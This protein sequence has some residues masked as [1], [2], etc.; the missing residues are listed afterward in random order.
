MAARVVELAAAAEGHLLA[1]GPPRSQVPALVLERGNELDLPEL[2][3]QYL[4]AHEAELGGKV[5]L[6]G[7]HQQLSGP[8]GAGDDVAG[9]VDAADHR[10]LGQHVEAA[11]QARHDLLVVQGMWSGDL[12]G[13]E[14]GAG[15]KLAVVAESRRLRQLAVA[16]AHAVD[17]FAA[18][19]G[20]GGDFDLGK[21]EN[22]SHVAGG[23][24]AA[25]DEAHPDPVHFQFPAAQ[26]G[27]N[28]PPAPDASK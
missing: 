18:D 20:Q 13:V 14:V 28:I 24:A 4:V 22:P 2:S 10:L 25:A 16:C 1:P 27:P 7:D 23:V 19:V 11:V 26:K 5:P 6:V 8:L 3:A 17:G 21:A 9:V 12:N 15:E